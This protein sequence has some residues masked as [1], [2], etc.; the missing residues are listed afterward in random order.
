MRTPLTVVTTTERAA[1]TGAAA[2][3]SA[4]VLRP[5]GPVTARAPA[6]RVQLAG[7]S[8][9]VPRSR[10]T[11][12]EAVDE[13]APEDPLSVRR[14]TAGPPTWRTTTSPLRPTLTASTPRAVVATD[15]DTERRPPRPSPTLVSI[16]TALAFEPAVNWTLP[17]AGTYLTV[18]TGPAPAGTVTA[19]AS[20]LPSTV[21]RYDPPARPVTATSTAFRPARTTQPSGPGPPL[22]GS[23]APA[24]A[25][26]PLACTPPAPSS[27]RPPAVTWVMRAGGAPAPPADVPNTAISWSGESSSWLA[28]SIDVLVGMSG[29]AI[30]AMPLTRPFDP[31]LAIAV[32]VSDQSPAAVTRTVLLWSAAACAA[33]APGPAGGSSAPVK[34][35]FES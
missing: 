24:S 2:P 16:V 3:R 1:S 18:P 12:A 15:S 28:L 32:P 30:S 35:T 9:V 23:G 20:P 6:S 5:R 17:D 31:A 10:R 26:A 34:G 33:A 8:T 14:P 22:I 7:R 25:V 11:T 13:A 19:P 29:Y 4:T 21:C 27:L